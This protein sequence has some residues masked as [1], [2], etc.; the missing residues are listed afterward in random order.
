MG[1]NEKEPQPSQND[2]PAVWDLVKLDI[3]ERDAIGEKIA[4]ICKE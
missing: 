4:E 3:A 1:L 2:L